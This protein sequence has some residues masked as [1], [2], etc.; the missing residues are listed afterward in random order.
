[1]LF[2]ILFFTIMLYFCLQVNLMYDAMTD[3]FFENFGM[4]YTADVVK[5]GTVEQ[6]NQFCGDSLDKAVELGK[7]IQFFD[8]ILIVQIIAISVSII[9]KFTIL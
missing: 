7:S 3:R 5:A 1:M 6:L 2:S 9:Q 4:L 8:Q